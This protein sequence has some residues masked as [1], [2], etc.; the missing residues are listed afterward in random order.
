MAVRQHA[1]CGPELAAIGWVFAHLF[2]PQAVPWSSRRPS[3]ATPTPGL[4]A[5]HT[6]ATPPAKA[7]R[8]PGLPAT[9]ET[10][11]A[12]YWLPP[13]SAAALSMGSRCATP[14]RWRSSPAGH[15][16]GA[17]PLASGLWAGGGR[18]PSAA[19]GHREFA[20]R[21]LPQRC[22]R[23]SWFPPVRSREDATIL[24]S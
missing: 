7:A 6:S 5:Y 2:P 23:S 22:P 13:S 15:P 4:S 24:C 18:A 1:P 10:G 16:S 9:P 8:T 14:T 12:P 17:G 11:H 3:P 19:T 21:G 20:T